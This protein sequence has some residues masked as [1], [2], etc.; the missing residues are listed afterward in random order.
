MA[1]QRPASICDVIVIGGVLAGKAASL[2]LAKAGLSVTCIEPTD[3]ARQAVAESLDWS[4]PELLKALGLPMEH[5]VNERIAT[6]KRH[7]TLRLRDGSSEQ[8][9]PSAWLA[10]NV[11]ADVLSTR[12]SKSS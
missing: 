12:F 11:S 1:A 2:H 3:A 10:R 6:W 7:I 4:A 5:L 8:Y 9:V